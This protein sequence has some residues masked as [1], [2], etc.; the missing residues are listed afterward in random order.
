LNLRV[1]RLGL[2]LRGSGGQLRLLS[3]L[4][5]QLLLM[6]KRLVLHGDRS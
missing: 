4:G 1:L 5:V 2:L 6:N 3:L